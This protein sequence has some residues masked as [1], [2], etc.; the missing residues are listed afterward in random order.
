[1]QSILSFVLA[2]IYAITGLFSPAATAAEDAPAHD[3]A[4]SGSHIA[5]SF[6]DSSRLALRNAAL[7]QRSVPEYSDLTYIHYDPEAFYDD[8]KLLRS[9]AQKGSADELISLYDRLYDEFLYIDSLSVLVMLEYDR[10]FYDEYWSEEY[11]YVNILWSDMWNEILAACA[12]VLESPCYKAFS[13]HIGPEMTYMLWYFTP[14]TTDSTQSERE[15]ELINQ[16]NVLYDTA[17]TSISSTYEGE[18]WTLD[19]LYGFRGT[20][21]ANR[22][23]DAYLE[24]YSDLQ[25][26]MTE[27]FAPVYIELVGIWTEDA[28]RAGYESYADYAYEYIYARDYTPSEA[29]AFCDAVKPIAREYYR[30][31]YYEDIGYDYDL[32]EP[33]LSAVDM[34]DVLG[35][36]LPRIDESLA[37]PWQ[38]MT[39][40][41]LYDMAVAA[42]GRY[43]G[44]YTTSMVRY[45]AP[46]L[47]ATLSG[48]CYDLITVTH[49]FGHFCDFWFNPQTN[50]F[51]QVDNLDL[52]EIHSNAMQA[53]F[54]GFYD[55]IF[56]ENADVA[57]FANLCDLFEN[58]IDGCL[59]DEFQRRVLSDPT[60]LDA[61]KL[62]SIYMSVCEEYGIEGEWTWDG[63]WIYISHNF[64]RPLY[65][66]SYAASAVAALQIWDAAQTDFRAAVDAYLGVLS[67]GSYRESYKQVLRSEGLLLFTDENA[68][69]II[70]RPVLDRLEELARNY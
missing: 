29:Q 17:E 35:E 47:F 14:D 26:Q 49:E 67:H 51:T 56:D 13:E 11:T 30:D 19:D 27:L 64:E 22:N 34:I 52:S 45:R 66:I 60:D 61:E 1:M 39:D 18:T 8:C 4:G 9:L 57:E 15:M 58:I 43:S 6:Q 12:D 36:Y 21:L 53:L 46:F 59:Y 7:N 70:C 32:V 16:Y 31:L 24:I 38:D 42:S 28:R 10:D 44:S 55:E 37:E 2:I 41:G 20:A 48:D 5:A 50:I 69:E 68:A 33:V 62:N 63:G 65:Y 23:Y 25:R 40:R 3:S 54:T